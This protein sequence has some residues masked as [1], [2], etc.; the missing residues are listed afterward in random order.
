MMISNRKWR[1]SSY[2]GGQNN[3]CVEL[4]MDTVQS[5]IR[6]SKNPTGPVLNV[7]NMAALMHEIKHGRF[8]L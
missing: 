1:K 7:G 3:N 6:D 8:D 4:A 5:S 2:S